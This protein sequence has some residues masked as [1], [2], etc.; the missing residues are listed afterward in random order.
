M[1]KLGGCWCQEQ[2]N[3]ILVEV[4]IQ[5]RPISGIQN[6]NC[7][8]WRRCSSDN[9]GG[10]WW[11]GREWQVLIKVMARV[12]VMAQTHRPMGLH[13]HFSCIHRWYNKTHAVT[14]NKKFYTGGYYR[15]INPAQWLPT[16][17]FLA[18]CEMLSINQEMRVKFPPPVLL[19]LPL[20]GALHV[21]LDRRIMGITC[22]LWW[23]WIFLMLGISMTSNVLPKVTF[24]CPH[25]CKCD[26]QQR[27]V[28]C[29]CQ[30]L[31][32]IPKGIPRETRSLDLNKNWLRLLRREDF[33]E[34]PLIENLK[35][36]DN[37]IRHIEPGVFEK[38]PSL[39]SLSLSGNHLWL[40]QNKALTGLRNL[41]TLDISCNRLMILQDGLFHDLGYLRH[42]KVGNSN[43]AY[44]SAWAFKGLYS[45]EKFSL[46]SCNL[47]N[48][49]TR[50]LSQLVNLVQLCIQHVSTSVLSDYSFQG[51]LQLRVLEIDCWPFLQVLQPNS[52]Q[53]LSLTSLT[54]TNTRL[55]AIP[56]SALRKMLHLQFLNLSHNPLKIINT[57]AFS[58]LS[59]LQQ[60]YLVQSQLSRIERQAFRGLGMLTVLNISCN[61]LQFFD[62]QSFQTTDSLKILG[63][64]SNPLVCSCNLLWLNQLL[65]N[66]NSEHI[67]TKCYM[68]TGAQ[69]RMMALNSF[70]KSWQCKVQ[71]GKT[72]QQQVARVGHLGWLPYPIPGAKTHHEQQPLAFN[73]NFTGQTAH[74]RVTSSETTLMK[75]GFSLWDEKWKQFQTRVPV[76]THFD[77]VRPVS[78]VVLPAE[79]S[80]REISQLAAN[81]LKESRAWSPIDFPF[82]ISTIFIATAMGCFT[83]L[84]VVLLC[85]LT[86]LLW[87]KSQGQH[88]QR[89]EIDYVMPQRRQWG[90]S[91]SQEYHFNMKLI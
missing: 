51:L 64:E 39:R 11:Q 27:S 14:V 81:G 13:C 53:G 54:I 40:L 60:L 77:E 9:G 21:Q 3:S 8:V 12:N 76:N 7:S 36:S 45:L 88:K 35:L 68:W 80:S 25:F 87:S 75:H 59:N 85:F 19:T 37:F 16:Y 38:L 42:L 5:F 70:L 2:A 29:P 58:Y 50:A 15:P 79:L 18:F 74:K 73:E 91:G 84:G 61:R 69:V 24:F 41:T 30:Y 52:L 20:N 89:T 17:G 44:I 34:H 62:D 49:P 57:G 63:V 4:Q 6:V 43:L 86:L 33:A 90:G 47:S 56:S 65:Q 46:K 26:I 83:F 23:N 28:S 82:D 72:L 71:K 66:L 78:S 1:T 55:A 31:T 32:V 10:E 22:A 48:V 67:G